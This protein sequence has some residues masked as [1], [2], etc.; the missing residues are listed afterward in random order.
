MFKLEVS[1]YGRRNYPRACKFATSAFAQIETDG[2]KNTPVSRSIR[3]MAFRDLDKNA[4]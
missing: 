2:G 3:R 4:L 1:A